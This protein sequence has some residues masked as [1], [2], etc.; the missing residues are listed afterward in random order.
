MPKAVTKSKGKK[1]AVK[2]Q[3]CPAPC[4]NVYLDDSKFCRKC[5]RKRN[6]SSSTRAGLIWS[7][8]RCNLMMKK[9]RLATRIGSGAGVFMAGVLQYLTSEM[10][11]LSGEICVEKKN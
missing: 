2:K 8:P 3:T 4:G 6:V 11:E 5:G 9:R 10:L 1:G 7:A